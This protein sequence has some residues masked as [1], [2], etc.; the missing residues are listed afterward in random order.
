MNP[1]P[2]DLLAL[3]RSGES[4]RPRLI[5]H[6][7][8]ERIELSGRVL[9]TWA[10]KAADFLQE[11][12]DAG[13]GTRVLLDGEPHWRFLAWALGVWHVGG[14]V[15]TPR[16][17]QQDAQVVVATGAR[18]AAGEVNIAGADTAVALTP[19]ALARVSPDPLP[20]GVI[21]EAATLLSYADEV[22]PYDRAGERDTALADLQ[23]HTYAGVLTT[24]DDDRR[25]LSGAGHLAE[26]LIPAASTWAA[27]G[28]IVLTDPA[29]EAEQGGDPGAG[30]FAEILAEEG[31]TALRG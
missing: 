10:A 12:A 3:L 23:E 17:R 4:A 25:H 31:V 9:A 5:W 14:A 27:G 18:I 15:V 8:G 13:V 2:D 19:A 11:E 6:A 30:H 7:P 24:T 1:R 20:A 16:A 26:V 28:S 29:W 22:D 21:D